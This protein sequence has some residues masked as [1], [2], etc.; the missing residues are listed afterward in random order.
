MLSRDPIFD[1]TLSLKSSFSDFTSTWPPPGREEREEGQDWSSSSS[2]CASPP[3]PRGTWLVV[4]VAQGATLGGDV[5]Q[6]HR[7]VHDLHLPVERGEGM[8]WGQHGQ[9]G[10]GSTTHSST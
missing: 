7:L 6:V 2:A 3:E 8:S 1:C 10:R 5:A 4:D 9:L